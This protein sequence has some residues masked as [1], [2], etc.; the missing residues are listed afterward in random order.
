M[1]HVSRDSVIPGKFLL[2]NSL[3]RQSSSDGN[4]A[5][6][7]FNRPSAA[8][9]RSLGAAG[10]LR[11]VGHEATRV[12]RRVDHEATQQAAGLRSNAAAG[13]TRSIWAVGTQR[14][15]RGHQLVGVNKVHASF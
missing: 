7:S 13:G 9:F 5:L 12:L 8:S 1:C 2:S 14:Y 15:L 6:R 4:G 10:A 3:D 11:W